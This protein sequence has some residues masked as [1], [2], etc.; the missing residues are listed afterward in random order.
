MHL[1][2]SWGV[3]EAGGAER[4][5]W[6]SLKGRTRTVLNCVGVYTEGVEEG[7]GSREDAQTM[8]RGCGLTGAA[9]RPRRND[10]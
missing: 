9:R 6:L 10:I 8:A 3:L 2:F 5:L 1:Q 7:F 4:K